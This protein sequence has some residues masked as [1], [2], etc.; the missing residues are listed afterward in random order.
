MSALVS[1]NCN[2]IVNNIDKLETNKFYNLLLIPSKNNI[3]SDSIIKSKNIR[4]KHKD[5]EIDTRT[6]LDYGQINIGRKSYEYVYLTPG[7]E[8]ISV[9]TSTLMLDDKEIELQHDL[10]FNSSAKLLIGSLI[11]NNDFILL[12][13]FCFKHFCNFNNSVIIKF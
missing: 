7:L 10:T 5:L 4:L 2:S 1:S 9:N 6:C 8:N 13:Y 12:F 3:T 11:L